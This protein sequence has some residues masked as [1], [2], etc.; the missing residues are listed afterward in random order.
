VENVPRE[1]TVSY[2]IVSPENAKAEV[3]AVRAIVEKPSPKEAPSTLGV[4]GR[5]VLTPTIFELLAKVKP[6]SGG[7]IQLTDAIAALLKRERVVAAQIG[8]KRYDCG[9]KIGYLMATVEYGM[10][11]PETGRQFSAFM[12]KR[13]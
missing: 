2:G 13:K 5:Y 6:G 4:V 7:E 11:H 3:T 1:Q 10:R 9:N 8:G 12:R